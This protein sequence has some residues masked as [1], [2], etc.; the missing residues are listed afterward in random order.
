MMRVNEIFHSL[1]GEGRFSGCPA[2]FVRFSGCNLQCPFCDTHHTVGREMTEEDIVAEVKRHKARIVVFTGG[3][4]AMQLTRSLVGKL[5]RLHKRVHVETNGTLPLPPNVD[6]V[7]L[8]PKDLF[9]GTSAKPRPQAVDEVKVLFDGEHS[10][11]RYSAAYY[12]HAHHYLQPL[13]TGDPS[14]NRAITEAAVEYVKEHP[15]WA[16]SLQ[17]H[18]ILNIR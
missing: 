11:S 16:L 1:Q 2:V 15:E 5:H 13:D 3:E 9:L 12:K 4:P 18:K 14:R 8:S 6:W 10:P 17:I 7:T